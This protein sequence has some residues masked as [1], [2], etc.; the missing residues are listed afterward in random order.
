MKI[1]DQLKASALAP[2]LQK[3]WQLSGA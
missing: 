1:D 3:F 2:A